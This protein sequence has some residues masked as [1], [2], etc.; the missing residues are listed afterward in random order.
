MSGAVNLPVTGEGLGGEG[1]YA[2]VTGQ[3]QWQRLAAARSDGLAHQLGGGRFMASQSVGGASTLS[4]TGGDDSN[5]RVTVN[6]TLFN[7]ATST[8]TYNLASGTYRPG[9]GERRGQPAGDGRGPDAAKAPIPTC[10]SAT[11][12]TP[13]S[14]AW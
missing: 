12:A 3:F 8:S 9:R 7:S 14:S 13:C 4:T 1:P 10:W 2:D 11:A 5:T 6:G